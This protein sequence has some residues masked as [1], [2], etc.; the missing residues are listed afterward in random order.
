MLVG[1]MLKADSILHD[2]LASKYEDFITFC[3]PSTVSNRAIDFE[4]VHDFCR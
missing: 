3:T 2:D 1:L 4:D